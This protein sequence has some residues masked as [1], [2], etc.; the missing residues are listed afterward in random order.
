MAPDDRR[1]MIVR[2]V[3]PLV[4]EHGR[5]V[6]TA[7]IARAAG[8]GEGTIFRVFTDKDELFEACIEAALDPG[9][10]LEMIE[11]IPSDLPLEK[12]LL[13][14]VGALT[15]HLQRMGAVMAATLKGRPGPEE[16]RNRKSVTGDSR[17][18]SMEAMQRAVRELF[19]PD[20]DRLRL[21]VDKAASLFL[22][23]LFAQSRAVPG[24][25]EP[26]EMIDLFL[27][28]AVRE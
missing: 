11:E 7:Q 28:G 27:H 18:E 9:E 1:R 25:P 13:E 10:A 23:M 14:A 5:G 8:I 24:S 20:S 3:L 17:R 22:T 12:R 16:A 2:A 21:P 6:T 19:V 26:A 15:A 4:V